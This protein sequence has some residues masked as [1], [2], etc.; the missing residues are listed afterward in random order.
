MKEA[1]YFS[2]DAN[3]RTDPKI[4]AMRSVYG[5]E[6][7]GW[8]W[9]IVE[10]LREANDF[11]LDMRSKYVYHAFAS[12]MQ[13]DAS[14]AQEFINDCV[15]EFELFASDG[16]YFWSDSLLRRM[17]ERE[18]KSEK[19]RQSARAR[20]SR[21][22]APSKES[23]ESEV[24]S[25]CVGNANA[26]KND[27]LKESKVKES[28]RKEIKDKTFSAY[29]SNVGL[30]ESLESFAEFRK[31][32]KKPMTDKAITLLLGNLDKLASSDE[33][34]IAILEQSILNGW[35]SIYEL[36]DKRGGRNARTGGRPEDPYAGINFGF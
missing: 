28:K 33:D 16:S 6:G 14:K 8:Y 15:S 25:D 17:Q 10:M 2:H 13:C 5:A 31:K 20:W 11:K 30:I 26:S 29:T 12:Q 34:K 36:K 7:Y 9:I 32:I 4:S 35:Q 27:A 21:E 22:P 3:A 1:Y 18:L 19:A 23:S 24:Q